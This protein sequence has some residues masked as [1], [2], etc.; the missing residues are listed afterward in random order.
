M[1]TLDLTTQIMPE[2]TSIGDPILISLT[3]DF[4][5]DNNYKICKKDFTEVNYFEPN[6][7]TAV[8]NEPKKFEIGKSYEC[9]LCKIKSLE[10][11]REFLVNLIGKEWFAGGATGMILFWEKVRL[12]TSEYE[13]GFCLSPTSDHS[14][15]PYMY[16]GDKNLILFGSRNDTRKKDEEKSFYSG[17]F[18]LLFK[19][20]K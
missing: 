7:Q 15:L 4:D 14:H 13:L 3:A 8:T 18:I 20:V 9:Q 17:E 11:M 1:Y 6:L 10:V 16:K 5:R 19:E 2:L 12:T